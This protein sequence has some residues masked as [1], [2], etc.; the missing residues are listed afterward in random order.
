MASSYKKSYATNMKVHATTVNTNSQHPGSSLKGKWMRPCETK[1][2]DEDECPSFPLGIDSQSNIPYIE[3]DDGILRTQDD[4]MIIDDTIAGKIPESHQTDDRVETS[5]KRN[6]D[7]GI[8]VIKFAKYIF[9][10]KIKEIPKKFDAKVARHNMAVQ[11]YIFAL[12]KPDLHM[13]NMPR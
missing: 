8:F 7:C 2:I 11:L 6:G 3:L 4:I 13:P 10:R 12:E 9:G 1:T 5:K